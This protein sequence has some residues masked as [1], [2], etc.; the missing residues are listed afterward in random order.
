MYIIWQLRFMIHLKFCFWW[1]IGSS[2]IHS[3]DFLPMNFHRVHGY[4]IA[5]PFFSK[6]WKN[7]IDSFSY[8]FQFNYTLNWYTTEMLLPR[9][10]IN[11]LLVRTWFFYDS[12]KRQ[13]SIQC[14]VT[15]KNPE[16]EKQGNSKGQESKSNLHLRF[17]YLRIELVEETEEPWENHRPVAS[18]WQTL[19]HNVVS[20][21][22]RLERSPYSQL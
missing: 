21:T 17:I 6:L 19:S 4:R 13:S 2:H 5:T 1:W 12:E 22:P 11:S 16:I 8:Y 3:H 20:S 7:H 18:H 9:Y 15:K 10:H 14:S